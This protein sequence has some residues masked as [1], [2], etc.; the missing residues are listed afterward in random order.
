MRAKVVIKFQGVDERAITFKS[1]KRAET[2][3]R[4]MNSVTDQFTT[5]LVTY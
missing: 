1:V 3:L 4:N 2:F 5:R